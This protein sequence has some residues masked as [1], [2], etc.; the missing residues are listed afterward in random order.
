M[1]TE[2]NQSLKTALE[3]DGFFWLRGYFSAAE[4]QRFRN[5]YLRDIGIG[6]RLYGATEDPMIVKLTDTL[7][8]YWPKIKPRQFTA[9]DKSSDN[10]W[11]TAWH[12][13]RVIAV[14]EKHD[15]PGFKNWTR[16][17]GNWFCE[18]PVHILE[19][20]LFARIHFDHCDLRNG[21]LK[22]L[23]GSHKKGSLSATR[24]AAHIDHSRSVLCQANSGDV[25]IAK[26]L[27]IHGSSPSTKTTRR[28]ALRVDYS[29]VHLPYPLAWNV[30][31]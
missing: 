12:Q 8:E 23:Q 17:S 11:G 14:E 9:F 4:L 28:L 16:K 22:L 1:M 7:Q 2:P 3:R 20:Q 30:E 6:T 5:Q 21:C 24:L 13:D 25:L 18:P 31:D 29:D 26:A 27:I 19:R 10:N 15:V